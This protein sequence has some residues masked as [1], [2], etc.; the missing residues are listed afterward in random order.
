V[1]VTVARERDPGLQPERT[2]LAWRRTTLAFTVAAVLAARQVKSG[3]LGA[4]VLAA[5]A[6]ST[7]VWLGFLRVAHRRMRVLGAGP[8]PNAMS[9]PV[10]LAATACTIALAGF[11]VAVVV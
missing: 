1:T 10:A 4:A 5:V 8:R 3:E 6:C 9:V 2:G 7:L 11:A